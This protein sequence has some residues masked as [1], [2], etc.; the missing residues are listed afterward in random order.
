MYFVD[1]IIN[2][3]TG[4]KNIDNL[5]HIFQSNVVY[6][7]YT[8]LRQGVTKESKT[9]GSALPD[10]RCTGKTSFTLCFNEPII[11]FAY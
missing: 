4:R 9:E 2:K 1:N 3:Q 6:T 11:K 10:A 7:Y 5:Q 8:F